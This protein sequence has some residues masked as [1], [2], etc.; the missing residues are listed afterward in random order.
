MPAGNKTYKSNVMSNDHDQIF[1]SINPL[2][3]NGFRPVYGTKTQF[4]KINILNFL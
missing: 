4:R 1:I 2:L 3:L